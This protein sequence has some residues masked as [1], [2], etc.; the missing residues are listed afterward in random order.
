M[1]TTSEL[2]SD[3]EKLRAALAAVEAA[4]GACA[5]AGVEAGVLHSL[6]ATIRAGIKSVE[7]RV[8]P[9]AIGDEVLVSVS[10]SRAGYAPARLEKVARA[11]VYVGGDAYRFDDGEAPNVTGYGRRIHSDDLFRIHRDLVRRTKGGG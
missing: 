6:T 3:V 8:L 2:V 10:A 9:V 7:W 5:D 1:T 11:Y 4:G